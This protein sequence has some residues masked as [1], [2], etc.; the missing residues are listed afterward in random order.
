MRLFRREQDIAAPDALATEHRPAS[1]PGAGAGRQQSTASYRLWLLTNAPSPYQVELFRAIADGASLA[2]EVR[3]MRGADPERLRGYTNVV[4]RGLAP[5]VWSDTFRVHP[6]ALREATVG[7]HDCYVLSGTFAS[8]TFLLCA[9]LLTLRR[10]PWVMWLERPRPRAYRVAWLGGLFR[11]SVG[12]A[13]RDG[14]LK[15]LQSR[16]HGII[17]MGTAARQEYAERGAPIER[18]KVLPYCCDVGRYAEVDAAAVERVRQRHGLHGKRVFLFSGQMIPRKGVDTLIEAFTRVAK[19]HEDAALVLL[20]DGPHRADYERM[21]PEAIRS[22]VHFAGFLEQ[23]ELP[24]YFN[25][26]DAF[27]FPSRHDGWAVVINEA[28]GAGLPIVTTRQTGAA[29]DLVCEGENGYVLECDDVEGFAAAMRRLLDEPALMQ[30]MGEA[31]RRVIQNYTVEQGAALFER[32][33]RS[34]V[35]VEGPGGE[36]RGREG[37]S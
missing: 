12:R 28:C 24:P 7:R 33:V 31:S 2:M 18:L 21:V 4:M 3:Y 34:F 16:A 1:D 36:P 19:S 5:A 30:R 20:G 17:C 32:H 9:L 6:R 26:A 8:S 29:R 14:V 11:G 35:D 27:V 37:V 15:L 23:A 10:K 13:V 25:A 22:R